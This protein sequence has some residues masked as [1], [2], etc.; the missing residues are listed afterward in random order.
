MVAIGSHIFFEAHVSVYIFTDFI[1]K[2]AHILGKRSKHTH[3]KT[4]TMV[5]GIHLGRVAIK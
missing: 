4:F 1:V 3:E 5:A 2:W